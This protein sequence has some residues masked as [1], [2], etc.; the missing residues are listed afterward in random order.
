LTRTDAGTEVLFVFAHQDDEVGA[1]PWIERE[2]RDGNRVSCLYLTDGGSRTEPAVRDAE[3]LRALE[4]LGVPP[5]SVAFLSDGERVRDNGLVRVL[6]RAF[7]AL[8][9]WVATNLPGVGRLYTLAW[10]GGHPDHDAAYVLTVALA[11]A[12]GIRDAWQFSLYNARRC[13]RPLFRVLSQLPASGESRVI[14]YGLVDAIRYAT[15]CW[16]HTS[17]VRTWL[18]LFPELA[19]RRLLLRSESVVRIDQA[20]SRRRPH[21]GELLYERMFGTRYADV[22]TRTDEFL[23]GP[24]KALPL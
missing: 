24:Q 23:D 21:D 6:P 22:R 12:R 8:N 16:R 10:E 15:I 14:R 19:I 5:G 17:Q 3:S 20:R 13:P 18:G 4:T 11:D 1:A 2:V 7:A 9:A